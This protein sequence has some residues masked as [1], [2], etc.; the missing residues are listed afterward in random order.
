MSSRPLISPYPV[1]AS[2]DMSANIT[3][4]VTILSNLSMASYD[5]SWT[6]TSPVGSVAVQVSNTYSKNADGSIKNAGN[7][8]TLP[9]TSSA[10][11]GNS[12]NGFI[13]VTASAGYAIRLVYTRV[14]GVG[15]MN[16]T[17]A[18]KVA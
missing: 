11:S 1:I 8:S 18:C 10:I 14:S 6:G 3:S 5:I 2:G 15:T 4:S 13:D 17:V 9:T 16:V 12:G 7:W